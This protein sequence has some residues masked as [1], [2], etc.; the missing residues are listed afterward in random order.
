[1]TPRVPAAALMWFGLLGPP[2]A[3]TAMHVTALFLSDARCPSRAP[4]ASWPF[5][6]WAAATGAAAAAIAFAGVVAAVL[7]WRR[8]RTDLHGGGPLARVHFMATMA[9]LVAPLSLVIIVMG[10][11]GAIVLPVCVQS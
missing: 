7:A 11:L 9:L 3:W 1:M 6:A 2:L 8:T 10:T 4:A 5:D